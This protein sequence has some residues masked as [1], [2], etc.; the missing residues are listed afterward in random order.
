MA[1]V[2]TGRFCGR[3]R[4]CG[5]LPPPTPQPR[6]TD[7]DFGRG[8]LASLRGYEGLSEK[9]QAPGLLSSCILCLR[10]RYQL[11]GDHLP[12]P[13]SLAVDHGTAQDC[14]VNGGDHASEYDRRITDNFCVEAHE[15]GIGEH[16]L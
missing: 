10:H 16:W 7:F 6:T 14:R 9:Q 1:R 13:C 8:P 2:K 15:A 12:G 4:G 11:S 3:R 5:K